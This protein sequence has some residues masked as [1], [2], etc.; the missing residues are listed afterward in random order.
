MDGQ[1]VTRLET[2]YLPESNE[3]LIRMYG[4]DG[5]LIHEQ[6]MAVDLGRE[7]MPTS[8]EYG[9]GEMRYYGDAGVLEWR[10]SGMPVYYEQATSSNAY[11]TIG[12][13]LDID[14][15]EWEREND[16]HHSIYRQ[17]YPWQN[18]CV[19]NDIDLSKCAFLY[20][21]WLC[22]DSEQEEA[23]IKEERGG[24]LD[25]FIDGLKPQKTTPERSDKQK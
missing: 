25:E 10:A 13:N 18:V 15:Q 5:E 22:E 14:I 21:E 11:P 12:R 9:H 4:A 23:D 20:G 7:I 16:A 2:T 8:V 6:I 3:N 19:S 24:A 1:E 17:E